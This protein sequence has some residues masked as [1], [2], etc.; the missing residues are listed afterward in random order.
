MYEQISVLDPD[1]HNLLRLHEKFVDGENTCLVFEMLDMNLIQL[2]HKLKRTLT[3]A[4]IRP[5]AQQV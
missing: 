2:L 4:E 5:I 3:L 1:K